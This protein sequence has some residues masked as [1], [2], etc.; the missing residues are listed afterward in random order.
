MS[1]SE[2]S[3]NKYTLLKK[4][5][6]LFLI[7]NVGTKVISFLL[8]PILTRAL[9][10]SEFGY[11]EL[12]ISISSLLVPLITFNIQDA[13][14]RFAL[15]NSFSKK[16]VI[17]IG[18]IVNIAGCIIL[19]SSFI[20]IFKIDILNIKKDF[21]SFLFFLCLL[22]GFNNCLIMY[23]KA[24]NLVSIIL[25]A[26]FFSGIVNFLL[27]ILLLL[28]INMGLYG[29]LIAYIVS[30]LMSIL[31]MYI[32]GRVYVDFY[33]KV[34]WY[35][36]K[37]MFNYS[38]PLTWNSL[39]W[40]VNNTC[41]RYIVIFFC[42]ISAGGIY[43]VAYKIPGILNILQNVF[44]NSWSISAIKEFDNKDKDGFLSDIFNMYSMGIIIVC[45]VIICM[46]KFLSK[47]LYANDFLQL[48]IMYL[49]F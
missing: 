24:T 18:I 3:S 5:T 30:L 44:Y 6:F 16:D 48:G 26:S 27:N 34:D 32:F 19:L 10:T 12:I 20:V 28:V 38:F 45:S 49:F 41:D 46:N 15:D 47:L 11:I 36:L 37:K 4:N 29:Y 25:K 21:L 14:I 40:W 13:I 1:F 9:T 8:I 23:L 43:S 22:G 42:G 35:L 17:S 33:L 39:A 7:C 2:N 31:Y